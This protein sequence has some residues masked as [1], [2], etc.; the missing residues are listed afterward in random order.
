M[1][2]DT[3]THLEFPQFDNDRNEV[4]KKAN[5]ENIQIINSGM[6]PDRI[7]KTLEIIEE[8][9]NVFAT[10]GL[11]PQ[12]F[13]EKIIGETIALIRKHRDKIVGIGEVGLDYYWVKDADERKKEIENF[14][15]FIE[16]SDELNL[17]LV[18]HS[19]DAEEDVIDMLEKSAKSGESG[20]AALMHCFSGSVEQAERAISFGCLISIPV[21]IIYSKQKQRLAR[22]I[23]LESM[24]LETD[25]PY[26]APVPRTRNE[27]VNIKL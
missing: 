21:N 8:H 18:I 15:K 4:I 3:H 5:E 19:R 22:E 7:Q 20:K 13:D 1:L 11:S 25:A 2:I 16:L 27:P 26:L 17:P 6:G 10:F 24:V 12:E 9:D 23:P 14:K